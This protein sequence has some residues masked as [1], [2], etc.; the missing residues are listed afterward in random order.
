MS[1]IAGLDL[2]R[3]RCLG[4]SPF[5]LRHGGRVRAVLLAPST[6]LCASEPSAPSRLSS[7]SSSSS[8]LLLATS[9]P[10]TTTSNTSSGGT[11]STTPIL[12]LY[13]HTKMIILPRPTANVV[14]RGL[15]RRRGIFSF[16]SSTSFGQITNLF[17][18]FMGGSIF[19]PLR[20]PPHATIFGNLGDTLSATGYIAGISSPMPPDRISWGVNVDWEVLPPMVTSHVK[21]S[22]Q[23]RP[24]SSLH[25]V[26]ASNDMPL[27]LHDHWGSLD[28]NDGGC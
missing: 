28:G 24:W 19:Y 16:S 18:S 2:Q 10:A 4:P 15:I 21:V 12:F 11:P 22:S 13:H 8:H 3:Q 6:F 20:L 5:L 7:L 14:L 23:L 27:T 26:T 25:L 9:S 1:P 17:S